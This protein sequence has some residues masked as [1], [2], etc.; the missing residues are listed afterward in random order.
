MPRWVA[1]HGGV[2][3]H[4]APSISQSARAWRGELGWWVVWTA[5]TCVPRTSGLQGICAVSL[6]EASVAGGPTRRLAHGLTRFSEV[7][8]NC[9]NSLRV[10]VSQAWSQDPIPGS[11]HLSSGHRQPHSLRPVC[12]AT[13]DASGKGR[14]RGCALLQPCP[15]G[16]QWMQDC[17]PVAAL[18]QA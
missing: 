4:P 13:E 8:D 11:P 6:R 17:R 18:A 12:S 10:A 2:R 1:W 15:K 14:L 3:S 7:K 16:E 5:Q 9:A